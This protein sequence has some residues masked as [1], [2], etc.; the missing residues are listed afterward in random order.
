MAAAS[1]VCS[2]S[3]THHG[4]PRGPSA[5]A[6]RLSRRS[7]RVFLLC[8]CRSGLRRARRLTPTLKSQHSD[9]PPMTCPGATRAPKR[10]REVRNQP[11]HKDTRPRD[12]LG[13]V[14]ARRPACSHPPAIAASEPVHSK[15]KCSETGKKMVTR[16]W[17]FVQ[18]YP[19]PARVALEW[20]WLIAVSNPCSPTVAKGNSSCSSRAAGRT[21]GQCLGRAGCN[22]HAPSWPIQP[23]DTTRGRP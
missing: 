22:Q 3:Y 15:A 7:L 16:F 17:D 18:G 9:E 11:K 13:D 4:R 5:G 12:R 19:R 21:R 2:A 1:S 6:V 20:V 10:R 23:G 8:A 14:R